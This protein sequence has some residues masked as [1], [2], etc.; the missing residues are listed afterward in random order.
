MIHCFLRFKTIH[1][2]YRTTDILEKRLT[3][4]EGGAAGLAVSSGTSAC[5]YAIINLAEQGD[6]FVSSRNLYGG[7]YTQFN[8]ILPKFGIN[9]N[10]VDICDLSVV[11]AAIN[12]KTRVLFCETVSNPTLEI[13]PLEELA[14]IANEGVYKKLESS[15]S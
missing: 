10:F 6:N 7:T 15:V 13:S 1:Y 9:T 5:F 2:T 14:A 12:D 3:A 4:M 8:D 11:K